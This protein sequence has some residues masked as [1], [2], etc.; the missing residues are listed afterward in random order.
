M[1]ATTRSPDDRSQRRDHGP[2]LVYQRDDGRY[3]VGLDL[4]APGPF[5]S[6]QFAESVAGSNFPR[7]EVS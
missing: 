4:D 1:T 2:P 5:E 7:W 3:Q 6:R